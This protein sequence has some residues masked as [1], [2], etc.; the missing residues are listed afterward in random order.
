MTKNVK[1]FFSMLLA[2]S[3][4]FSLVV[5]AAATETEHD[6]VHAEETKEE[7]YL[8]VSLDNVTVS[9]SDI[10]DLDLEIDLESP[11]ILA[12]PNTEVDMDDPAIIAFETEL[13]D[14]T[15]LNAEG[16]PVPLT[17]EQIQNVL[18]L[19]QQYLDFQTANAD[20][21]GLQ[22]PF[23][24]SYND[25]GEDGLGILGEMLVLSNLPVD[26]VRAGYVTYDDL[27]GMI[28]NFYYGEQL[29]VQ[30][31]GNAIK[32]ARDEAL[33]AIKASG[34]QTEAQKL[35]VLN[36][37]LAH[38]NTFDM[39]YIMNAEK[40]EDARPM[41]AET[42]VKHEHY[43]DVF[44]VMNEVYTASITEQ[45]KTQIY[46]GLKA[47]FMV[48][49]YMGAIEAVYK[50]LATAM[51]VSEAAKDEQIV[52]V[53]KQGVYDKAYEEALAKGIDEE[54]IYN[55]AY[56]A[57]YNDYL[58]E[59]CE[60]DFQGAF[61]FTETTDEEGN[62][63]G[64][65]TAVAAEVICTKCGRIHENVAG[66]VTIETVPADCDE[67][68][69]TYLNAA[70][71]ITDAYHSYTVTYKKLHVTGTDALGHDWD[72]GVVTK[73]PVSVDEP[74]IM[75]YTCQREGCGETRTEEIPHEHKAV[76]GVAGVVTAPTCT[77]S[78][79][80][81]YECTCG[82]S[83]VTDVTKPTGHTEASHEGTAP[84]CT[85]SGMTGGKYCSVCE[86]V[87]EEPQ[88][89]EALGHDF[90]EDGVCKREG[91]GE[92]YVCT[93]EA[94]PVVKNAN[95]SWDFQTDP[96]SVTASYVCAECGHNLGEVPA[97]HIDVELVNTVP[98]TCTEQGTK[99]YVAT[100][101]YGEGEAE[102]VVGEVGRDFMIPMLDH[103]YEDGKCTV[104][105]NPDPDYTP[106]E[107]GTTT[108][109][110]EFN[111]ET[112]DPIEDVT[113]VVAADPTNP[114]L[115]A[116]A[117]AVA[118]AAA[119]K[120]VAD[121]NTDLEAAAAAE[122]QAVVDALTEE[123]IQPAAE[124]IVKNNPE[125]MA[126][127]EE[128]AAAATEA[129]MAENA[130]AI[131]ADPVGFVD[132]QEMFQIQVPV[133]DAEG[134]Y[135]I[136][137]DGNPMMM[138]L[139]QQLHMGWEQFWADAEKNGVEVDPVN[140]PGYKMTVEQ[141]IEQQMNTPMSDLP[142]KYDEQGNPVLDEEG[143]AVHMTP[144][145]AIPVFA[146]EAAK[147][148]TN[149][150][151]NYWEGSHF[152]ALGFGT[153]VCLGYTK[154]FTYLVQ[155]MHP[156]V[157][158]VNGE[159]TNMNVPGNWKT[160]DQ[161]YVYNENNEIDINQNYIVDAV[162]ISFAA[163][164]TMYGQTEDNF[165][166]DHFWNAVKVDG[167]WYYI[168]PCYTDVF[169]E[170]MMRDRVETDGQM[171]H[172][173]FLF[174]HP[175]CADL[176]EGN[177]SEI[178]T[179][180][181]TAAT[182]KT[183]EDSWMSRIKSNTYFVDGY[184]YYL[185]DST[186]M[187]T[188]M[189]EYE[190]SQ[191]NQNSEVDIDE[192]TYKL[193][194]H[195]LDTT[196]AGNGDEDYETLVIFNYKADENADPVARVWDPASG[197]MVNNEML[198]ELWNKH[199]AYGEIYPSIA[200]NAALYE[201][202]VYFNLANCI[203]SYD[204]ATSEVALVKEYNTVYGVRDKTNPFGGMA[205]STTTSGNADFTIE[206]H[207]IAG[208]TI[209]NDGIM[210]VSIATNFAFISGKADRCDPA[211]EGYGYAY[212]ES[213]FNSNYNSY[214]DFGDYTDEE[215]KD[216]GYVKEINDND[217]FMWTANF[218]EKLAMSDLTG[219]HSY[220]AV[221]V[222]ATC[223]VDAFTENRCTTCGAV[224][225]GS[226]VYEEG[227]ALNHHYVGFDETFYTKDEGG[228]WN[229]GFCYVCTICGDAVT[230]PVKPTGQM[231]TEE[232]QAAYEEKLAAYN[233]AKES[234]GHTYV[235]T[236]ET[237]ADDNSSV[238]FE[239]LICSSVCPDRKPHLDC[240]MNDDTITITLAE[241]ETAEAAL[242]NTIGTC[243]E[244]LIEVY[245]ASGEV[246]VNGETF[247][248]TFTKEVSLDPTD[249]VF[250]DGV[251]QKCGNCLVKRVAGTSRVDTA[252][253]VADATKE[254]LGVEKFDTI[255]LANGED[256][257]FADALTGSYLATVKKAPIL[258]YRTSGLSDATKA[259]IENNLV[260]GGT[261]YLLGGELAIPAEVEAELSASYTVKRLAGGSRYDTNLA[262]LKE[263][264]VGDKEILI[265]RGF[266]FADSLSASATGLPILMVNEVTG[267]LTDSQIEFLKGLNGNK[268]T[269]LGG[270]V[271]ISEELEATIEEVVGTDVDRVAGSSREATSV[272]IAKRYFGDPKPDFAVIAYSRR[273]P[274]GLCG[275][276]LA[277]AMGA[278]LLLVNAGKEDVSNTYIAENEIIAGYVLGGTLVVT[279]ETARAVFGLA[280]DAVIE[281][282]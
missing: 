75:T 212:E 64:A 7:A 41:V 227:T 79:Y 183:Y 263:A 61:T 151:I 255:I 167:Q 225:P 76:E 51:G 264:G 23:F 177:Y 168:D 42:P 272:E 74:G 199:A 257:N 77:A 252:L 280:E 260:S 148:L 223:G 238:T 198:T 114:D 125:A 109:D 14:F 161:I 72:E 122:A 191:E 4:V 59:H 180:Y 10:G 44:A 229:T 106:D 103:N 97:D 89:I 178:K 67:G 60:H 153:S 39:P 50:E 207:P 169:T 163:Q 35:L 111:S 243:P 143:N 175:S 70:A 228:A 128:Q 173:Y 137:D 5:P 195:Q 164:V 88:V 131:Q 155:C 240:L 276:P 265:A 96:P 262:I 210:Y 57:A 271:A 275:G 30:Y 100:F 124:E 98:A 93:H 13:K 11:L 269:I 236:G 282:K 241:P 176:Y 139:A 188:M 234:A 190:N 253:A 196:D 62:P 40:E 162:R 201:G 254:A 15:V 37:W 3:M 244:G 179:L 9:A 138:T 65:Y 12:D 197:A 6:H 118:K 185:Y 49:Y 200:V 16:D 82:E 92:V 157:Y 130:E 278:P 54:K 218:V 113:P 55:D 203:L 182:D 149:G 215:L 47:N 166:S 220:S 247:P 216:M 80:T 192:S 94:G 159:S 204:V 63:T 172:L 99:R 281:M 156:E 142:P 160:R 249:C 84:T 266:E 165:N 28:L 105:D 127:I 245:E 217:E 102:E 261:V 232:N 101:T 239:T 86:I 145:E 141:I 25:N 267:K 189:E 251:C 52:A 85:E 66:T 258:M 2:L 134:N 256:K 1:R 140:A 170:V 21:L 29:G 71:T 90:G 277:Y 248:Y 214:M 123:D 205:F 186:D 20:V 181:E 144:N 270:T 136:G 146:A 56:D 226:R 91:C 231:D 38:K 259:Y 22:T 73:E 206:N 132:S 26:A 133:T 158:G 154:A 193:V 32:A 110:D 95:T 31:Y 36:D 68:T 246:E 152:G 224:E 150:I 250:V 24:L 17:P 119:E 187:I 115:V 194:R 108:P 211:S 58:D 202:K 117:D 104:C 46:D 33:N 27:T 129:Y 237:W 126:A 83:F 48:Q 171:N 45:F 81:T 273:C 8:N 274:D 219:T 112:P 34:A 121:A 69:K 116:D 279:D 53:V 135:I 184:A 209:K 208:M 213:N 107:G 78:G 230:E 221:S 242:V 120:A 87:L 222:A 18:S 233:A 174:S 235:T 19:Y 43:D 268:L 147:G